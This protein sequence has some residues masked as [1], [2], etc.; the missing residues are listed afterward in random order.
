MGEEGAKNS[1][2]IEKMGDLYGSYMF[3]A[4]ACH[5]IYTPLRPIY[6]A[7]CGTALLS[8]AELEFLMWRWT[9]E[10][11]EQHAHLQA[12]PDSAPL[13]A[14][15]ETESWPTPQELLFQSGIVLA[16]ALGLVLAIQLLL[17]YMGIP[18]A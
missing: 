16:V 8:P 2:R 13:E 9:F 5:R 4:V 14:A 1:N 11:T 3:S 15:D 18:A 10:R 7:G 6:S 17:P 12:A